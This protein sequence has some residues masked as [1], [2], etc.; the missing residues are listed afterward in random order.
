MA[1]NSHEPW[2]G[3][4]AVVGPRAGGGAMGLVVRCSILQAV[5]VCS[6]IEVK[7]LF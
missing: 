2:L 3:D 6:G 4:L 5:S 7:F 1:E